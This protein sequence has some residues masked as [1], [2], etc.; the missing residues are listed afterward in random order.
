LSPDERGN[1]EVMLAT[2]AVYDD[3]IA[4]D[5]ARANLGIFDEVDF[6][7]ASFIQEDISD[8]LKKEKGS[9]SSRLGLFGLLLL[10]LFAEIL[11]AYFRKVQ[12][13]ESPDRGPPL[14]QEL[15][16]QPPALG[17]LGTTAFYALARRLRRRREGS[18]RRKPDIPKT[19]KATVAKAGMPELIWRFFSQPSQYLL[20]IET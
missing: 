5:T 3:T 2:K 10:Y 11:I 17:F 6:S 18:H 7:P 12:V 13:Q 4:L 14:R 16:M 8:L 20:L 1:I 9:L 19:L 15:D